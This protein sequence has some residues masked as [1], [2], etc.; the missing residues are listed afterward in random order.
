LPSAMNMT[1]RRAR[2]CCSCCGPSGVAD[3]V[4]RDLP[5]S[6]GRPALLRQFRLLG[7]R[8]ER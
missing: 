6:S 2:S 7:L 3:K 4:G 1:R 5:L 8:R